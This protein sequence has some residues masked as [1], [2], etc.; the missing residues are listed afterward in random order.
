LRSLTQSKRL[1]KA[2]FKPAL[3][4]PGFHV[5]G[6]TGFY[7]PTLRSAATQQ[8]VMLHAEEVEAVSAGCDKAN[9]MTQ[10]KDV[11]A[12]VFPTAPGKLFSTWHLFWHFPAR[13]IEAQRSA[14]F[15]IL[16]KEVAAP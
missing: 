4:A 10:F 8:R 6:V 2:G 7:R 1:K 16:F 14:K 12:A 3:S 13:A 5:G 9:C 15:E 11:R